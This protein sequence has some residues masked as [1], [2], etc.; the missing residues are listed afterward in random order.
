MCVGQLGACKVHCDV[1]CTPRWGSSGG[2]SVQEWDHG[3]K[4][5]RVFLRA[6]GDYRGDRV[7]SKLE[8]SVL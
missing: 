6:V 7:S 5:E 2:A 1:A 4:R 3:E 8:K